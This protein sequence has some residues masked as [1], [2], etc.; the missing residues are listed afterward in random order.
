M[1][2]PLSI[3]FS[4]A[5]ATAALACTRAPEEPTPVPRETP[6]KPPPAT[7]TNGTTNAQGTSTV[8]SGT[9]PGCP[10]DPDPTAAKMF[11]HGTAA[12]VTPDGKR[13]EFKV[14]IA[15]TES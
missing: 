1:R 13:H 12:F 2:T 14:E 10:T 3:G 9:I 8:A 11:D 5:L 15:R 6:P 7:T 4:L